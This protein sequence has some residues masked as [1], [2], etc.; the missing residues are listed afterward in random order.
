MEQ[1][2]TDAAEPG[3]AV[4]FKVLVIDDSPLDAELA[5]RELRRAGIGGE[6]ATAA[7][8]PELQAVLRTFVPDVVLCDF[9]L[10]GFDGFAAQRIVR[11]ILPHVPLIFVTGTVTED[12]AAV[13]VQSGAADFVLKSNLRRLPEIVRRTVAHA[14]ERQRLEASIRDSEHR[15]HEQAVRLEALCRT[16]NDQQLQGAGSLT[17]L[18]RLTAGALRTEQSFR[19]LLCRIDGT[20]LVVIAAAAGDDADA[21]SPLP[22]IGSSE[23]VAET[24]FP[25]ASRSQAWDEIANMETIPKAMSRLGWR[26]A[27]ST[28]FDATGVR[29]LLK[30]GSP[31]PTVRAFGTEDIAYIEVLA[32][33]LARLLE[34]N[35]LTTALR[36]AEEHSRRH[37]A[38]LE[39]LLRLVND[40]ALGDE[41]LWPAM[42]VQ[43]ATAMQ[44]GHTYRGT[45]WRIAADEMTIVAVAEHPDARAGAPT[46][47]GFSASVATTMIGPLLAAG[48]GT[49]SWSD[50]H[51]EPHAQAY[52]HVDPPRSLIATT[53]NAAGS[54]WAL[55]FASTDAAPTP[56][57]EEEHAYIEIL[58]SHFANRVQQRWQFERIAF[59]QSHD[60]LTGLLSRSQFRSQAR[61][62]SRT[63]SRFAV[64]TIDVDAFRE[65]NETYGH[66]IGDAILVEVGSALR[67]RLGADEILGRVGGNTFSVF[68]PDSE[69]RA[70]VLARAHDFADAF[71]QGFSTGDRAGS[72]F[73]SRTATLGIAVAPD[74]GIDIDTI[75]S[76]ADAALLQ[77]KRHGHGS[78][79]SYE[80]GMEGDAVRRTALRNEL[81][82]A[83]DRNEFVLHYQPH[84][85]TRNGVVTGC[86][87]LIRWNHPTRGLLAPATFIPFAEQC[88]IIT[89]VDDW[90]LRN[91]CAA[92]IVLGA[93]RPGFRLYFNLSGR[94]AGDPK[95]VRTLANLA[96]NGLRLANLGVEITESD[97]MRDVEATR[98]V[99][100]A[101]RKLDVRIAID[102]FGTGY[103][104]LSVLKRLPVDI[105][106][107]D[108]SFVS[109]L[110]TD[111]NDEAIAETIISIAD[112][113]GF[114][115]LGEGAEK[116]GEVAWLRRHACR[117]VQGFAICRPLPLEDFQVW[118][119]A[120]EHTAS[121]GGAKKNPAGAGSKW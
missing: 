72:E 20:R 66:M 55:T 38:R 58:A 9:S 74:D 42:L 69:S 12:R 82:N 71:R 114:E 78:I 115:S 26:C 45:L 121:R 35:E 13:A 96:R 92:S 99:C 15:A 17:A 64:I 112:R 25:G 18:L 102:D 60:V 97:A 21:R 81:A 5:L 100:R 93:L 11:R 36:E 44:P 85:D 65:I 113:F 24:L 1:Q 87:A 67:G 23:P 31:D 2:F 86:E 105:V 37:A 107:I 110:L 14:R 103:S 77:A 51:D 4:R 34:V 43:A 7:D 95:L 59:Q 56:F 40:P 16:V 47:V 27:I 80:T 39:G 109:G 84:V 61:V 33:S 6:V 116:P 111:P 50:L 22:A 19:G 106:K 119:S 63:A 28:R 88:G 57:R 8:E 120:R 104:S 70:G 108:R 41:E 118:L 89:A 75:I 91:A 53:F 101:L 73:I 54:V 29:Y 98:R 76:H 49:R 32:T 48:G 10:R 90:V 46:R 117:Y 83:I 68:I 79:V 3:S 94:Q 62:R 30:F 52:A